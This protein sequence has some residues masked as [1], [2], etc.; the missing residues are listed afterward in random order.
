MSVA[1]GPGLPPALPFSHAA[2]ISPPRGLTRLAPWR[3]CVPLL[4]CLV[5]LLIDMPIQNLAPEVLQAAVG[6]AASDLKWLLS[7]NNVKIEVQAALFVAGFNQVKIFAG[8]G[9]TRVEVRDAIKND[10][11]LN[12]DDGLD[13]RAQMAMLL[14]AWDAARA[15]VSQE[16]KARAEYKACE[17]AR[18]VPN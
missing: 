11:G 12:P 3:C 18:P 2:D 10:I 1:G 4:R 5:V 6:S 7:D 9:E 16:L 8:L 17:L 13:S 14:A 15:T